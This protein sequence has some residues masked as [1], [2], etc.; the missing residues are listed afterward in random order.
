[1][2]INFNQ[3]PGLPG[4]SIKGSKGNV[5]LLGL[6]LYYYPKSISNNKDIVLNKINNNVSL[7]DDEP[8]KDGKKYNIGDVILDSSG[9]IYS[10][11]DGI[12][13]FYIGDINTSEFFSRIDIST[14]NGFER[15]SNKFENGYMIDNI[16]SNNPNVTYT[17]NNCYDTSIRDYNAIYYNDITNDG[18][19]LLT[20]YTNGKNTIGLIF[21]NSINAYR[22][23]NIPKDENIQFD[24]KNIILN[25]TATDV[26]GSVLTNDDIN[27]PLLYGHE[28]S[29]GDLNAEPSTD[30]SI[31][32]K[33]NIDSSL[34][35]QIITEPSNSIELNVIQ[36]YNNSSTINWGSSIPT[37]TIF[38]IDASKGSNSSIKLTNINFND[39]LSFICYFKVNNNGW[40]RTFNKMTISALKELI[41]NFANNNI[42]IGSNANG[43]LNL[44]YNTNWVVKTNGSLIQNI[45]PSEGEYDPTQGDTN[46]VSILFETSSNLEFNSVNQQIEISSTN[47]QINAIANINIAGRQVKQYDGYIP[48]TRP[49]TVYAPEH[50]YDF[51]IGAKFDQIGNIIEAQLLRVNPEG[52]IEE[53]LNVQ[54]LLLITGKS[55]VQ[56][57]HAGTINDSPC[58][59]MLITNRTDNAV[60]N[61][62]INIL[63]WN[64]DKG[65]WAYR[66]VR[67]YIVSNNTDSG[68]SWPITICSPA[69]NTSHVFYCLY[70]TTYN[71]AVKGEVLNSIV[72]EECRF[73]DLV[74]GWEGG[75]TDIYSRK[76]DRD[77]TSSLTNYDYYLLNEAYMFFDKTSNQ[78]VVSYE[79]THI[80]SLN[81]V[82]TQKDSF[83]IDITKINDPSTEIDNYVFN[84]FTFYD[85]V[86]GSVTKQ[87]Y[88]TS[89]NDGF[90]NISIFDYRG[91]IID[92]STNFYKDHFNT[93]INSEINLPQT[94]KEINNFV[95]QVGDRLIFRTGR[96]NQDYPLAISSPITRDSSLNDFCVIEK[97][98]APNIYHS[99]TFVEGL[100]DSYYFN[101]NRIL[102]WVNSK[103]LLNNI[104]KRLDTSTMIN[105]METNSPIQL[106][107]NGYLNTIKDGTKTIIS[108]LGPG[109]I[110]NMGYPNN[111]NFPIDME[112]FYN[113]TPIQ[114]DKV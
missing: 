20:A 87:C 54:G 18:K 72:I 63:Y 70:Y 100:Q 13:L 48:I 46:D 51:Y 89:K 110:H 41:L 62:I 96:T 11:I 71:T 57:I 77:V 12:D 45:S 86:Y 6:S 58:F 40:S 9:V 95:Y 8:L 28:L 14:Q 37:S 29:I 2:N 47:N 32:L 24:F 17:N 69:A 31:T 92:L 94:S 16:L 21:D 59:A 79:T 75:T 39:E 113:Q 60:F 85:K 73:Y 52:D 82:S 112:S 65:Q 4:Y 42:N 99:T 23:G 61:S 81:N 1:M 88:L 84:Q 55:R 33:W 102:K 93:Q 98:K 105:V 76:F 78:L 50:A 3:S 108:T 97:T 49:I 10:I 36:R 35:E 80:Q 103:N 101:D 26:S 5:G 91:N 53:L 43:S 74:E 111:Y 83:K 66:V 106:F 107:V 25:N 19:N 30:G 90:G 56:L 109:Y 27:C 67:G 7:I 22:I 44:T 104:D 68:S 64:S 15:I 34:W 114:I 38:N